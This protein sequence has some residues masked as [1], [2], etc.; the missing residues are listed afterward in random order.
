[1]LPY[2]VVG[3]GFLTCS[4]PPLWL[5]TPPPLPPLPPPAV[6]DDDRRR[7]VLDAAGPLDR[8]TITACPRLVPSLSSPST[9]PAKFDPVRDA[10]LNSPVTQSPPQSI[11]RIDLPHTSPASQTS[12]STPA[13]FDRRTVSPINRRAT[14][15]ATLLNG[16][17]Q[18]ESPLFTPTASRPPRSLSDLL[19]PSEKLSDVRPIHRPH[20][21]PTAITTSDNSHQTQSAPSI[22]NGQFT[23]SVPQ[24]FPTRAQFSYPP[25]ST[26]S[27]TRSP[28]FSIPSRPSTSSSVTPATPS[29]STAKP[30]PTVSVT[31]LSIAE[32]IPLPPPPSAAAMPPP[33]VPQ[34][35]TTISYK[36]RPSSQL[37]PLTPQEI[38]FYN[39]PE[40][41]RRGWSSLAKKRKRLLTGEGDSKRPRDSDAIMQHC[42]CFPRLSGVAG[43]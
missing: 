17:P 25:P 1:M 14:D 24:D 15:L 13:S 40:Q 39:N 3:G 18:S 30:S 22:S 20:P 19:Q 7:Y 42:V 12:V 11:S 34:K 32:D 23:F 4:R 37:V 27:P 28:I 16:P 2:E 31:S 43:S 35:Q 38:Q 8:R 5:S 41:S 9:M 6:R 21:R 33:P 26:A 36:P 29:H 10:V